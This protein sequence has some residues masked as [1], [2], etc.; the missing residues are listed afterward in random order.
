MISCMNYIYSMFDYIKRVLVIRDVGSQP[1]YKNYNRDGKKFI[2]S[3]N[4]DKV[5]FT[6]NIH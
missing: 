2:I 1:G 6:P 4:I 3:P 5:N